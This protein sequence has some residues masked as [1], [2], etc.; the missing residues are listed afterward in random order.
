M[1]SSAP[2]QAPRGGLFAPLKNPDFTR[3]WLADG[4]WWQSMWMEQIALGWI[5]L[6]L[7]DSAWWVAVVAFCRAGPLPVVG[8]FGPILGER[9]LRRHLVLFLQSVNLTGAS[10]LLLLYLAGGLQYW[11]LTAVA[12]ANGAA[13]A[14]DWPTRRALVPDLVGRNR[15]VDGMVLENV[16]QGLT[17]LTGPLLAGLS[18][19]RLGTGGALGFL[20][21]MSAGGVVLLAGLQTDSRSPSPPKGVSAAIL[22]LREGLAFVRHQPAILGTLAITVIMNAWAFPF[23]ALLPVIARDVLG[24]GPMGL[25]LLGSASGVGAMIGLLLVNWSR[26]RRSNEAIFA[27]G[28]LVAC[29]GLLGLSVSTSFGLSLAALVV[30]GIGQAGFSIM[31][32]SI[33][34]VEA[35]EEMRSRAMGALVLAIGSGPL[36]RIQGGAMAVMWGAPVAVGAMAMSA[37]LGIVVVAWRLRGF[38]PSSEVRQR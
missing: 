1:M 37:A 36:G 21:V 19:D 12:F 32:S 31:Q 29:I 13:W 6:E 15:V 34:L 27:G 3:L 8:L 10:A 38:L 17:R 23:Q 25:G 16:L 18:M 26:D 20:V 30:S 24:Q 33:I 2:A 5:A 11:H 9:F 14:L 4:L 28:S 22:R 7:T 35:S